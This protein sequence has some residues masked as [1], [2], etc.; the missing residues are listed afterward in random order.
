M[1]LNILLAALSGL[2]LVFAYP[3]WNVNALVWVWMIPLLYALWNPKWSLKSLRRHFLLG[4]IA[5][6]V[7][8]ITN[9]FWLRHS[10]RVI[11]GAADETWIGW[12]PELMGLGAVLAMGLYLAIYFGLWAMFAATVGRP[13]IGSAAPAGLFSS[14]LESL[15]SAS[16]NAA[17]WVAC[18][19]LRGTVMT[20]FGW[21]GLAVPLADDLSMVQFA[22]TVGVTGLSFIPVFCA[23]IG[24]NTVLRFAD[25]VRTRRVRPHLDFYCAVALVLGCFLYGI[26][27]LS[28]PHADES[29]SLRVA[30]VQQNISQ[31]E[32]WSGQQDEKI[33]QG[34]GQLTRAFASTAHPPDLIVWPESALPLPF[35]HPNHVP[36]LNEVLA[37]GDFSLLTGTDI[38]E[39]NKP[40]Y[41][42]A[43]LMRGSFDNHH[44]YRKIHLV[45][46][47]EYLPLRSFPPM[48]WLLSG[49]FPYDFASGTSTEPLKLEK[50]SGVEII[51]LICFEDTV[52]SLARK[53]VRDAPQL[54]VNMTNDGWFMHS[55]ANEQQLA[56]AVFRCI[57]LRRPMA[58]AANTG[59][60]C[61]IDTE[62]R[63]NKGDRLAD[64]KTGSV[65]IKG[66]LPKDVKLKKHPTMTFY[67]LHGDLFSIAMLIIA[68][69]SVVIRRVSNR[70]WC[71]TDAGLR[72]TK[73]A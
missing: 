67:A 42:G 5:G 59:V 1:L 18:E 72:D 24:Y 71:W 36:F 63:I 52:G 13:R 29:I 58:R 73:G 6:V 44:L 19:W 27:K 46:F 14:S 38:I 22:D 4:W 7:F 64:A 34:Y 45:P 30:L 17:A 32:K 69:A 15:R 31:A 20:G 12:G 40:S 25:E 37:L 65:F 16:L 60:T 56:N 43:A 33:Y 55:E 51:P 21:N 49:M 28:T 57:E 68:G 41:T 23:C 9:L 50:P 8:F 47:G 66:V 61:F 70:G 54:I 35:H 39:E 26:H 3:R 10:S 11:N 53:F 62:G 2:M 48:R